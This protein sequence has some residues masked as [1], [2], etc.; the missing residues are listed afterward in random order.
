MTTD[1]A[2]NPEPVQ[3]FFSKLE[4]RKALFSTITDTH[5]TLTSHF[6]AIDLALSQKSETLDSRITSLR[7]DTLNSLRDLQNREDGI[8]ERE[9]CMAARVQELKAS[10]VA[11]IESPETAQKLKEK[12]VS[13]MLRFYCRIMDANGLMKFLFQHRRDTAALRAEVS[14]ALQ[15]SVDPM[16]LVLDAAEDYVG[17][18]VEGKVGMADRRRACSML[19]QSVMPLKEECGVVSRTLK[20]R[21]VCALEKWKDVLGDGDRNSGTRP[22]EASMFL[23][24]VV[25]FGLKQEF[26]EDFLRKLVEKFSSRRDMPKL[27]IALGFG[28]KIPDIIDQLVKNGKEVEAVYF[29]SEAGLTK[30][31]PPLPLLKASLRN[32]K[33]NAREVSKKGNFSAAAVEKANSLELDATKAIMQCVEDLRLEP[34]LPIDGLKKRVEQLENARL[35][36]RKSA[37]PP[38]KPSRKRDRDRDRDRARARAHGTTLS[39]SR[40]PKAARFSTPSGSTYPLRSTHRTHLAPPPAVA[41][42]PVG[43]Y[44]YPPNHGGVYDGHVPPSYMP[45]YNDTHPQSPVSYPKQYGYPTTDVTSVQGGGVGGSGHYGVQGSYAESPVAATQQYGYAPPPEVAGGVALRGDVTAHYIRTAATGGTYGG[46]TAPP[47]SQHYG[48]SPP[49]VVQDGTTATY[50]APGAPHGLPSEYAAAAYDYGAAAAASMTAY[51]TNS[52]QNQQQQF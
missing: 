15:E 10:A 39:S 29:A 7:N 11:E 3:S 1:I 34:E 20:E 36:K 35:E 46:S 40:P 17:M 31:Y 41:R 4:A 28:K 14:D 49:R 38:S 27:A 21:A 12:K 18:K 24:I 48:Y 25:G 23:Q 33:R 42:Y 43:S 30:Q 19:I 16:R 9:I 26:Q 32:C 5:K 47:A 37:L 50:E 51:P 6:S 8:P 2:I 22:N 13:D 45:L 52:Y 44:S